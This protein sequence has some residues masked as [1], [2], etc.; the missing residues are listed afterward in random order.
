[1]ILH[2]GVVDLPYAHTPPPQGRRKKK[3]AA[4]TQT[5]GDVAEILEAEY[6]VMEHFWNLHS[7]DVIHDLEGS[8][9]GALHSVLM[10]SPVPPSAFASAESAIED[11]FKRFLSDKEMDALGFP[12]IPTQAA[13]RGVSKRHKRSRARRGPRPSFIDTGLYQASFK[14]WVEA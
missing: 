11:R 2:F 12:G 6:H 9:Q 14:A 13:L 5:T 4:G 10:G 3:A 1:M 7:A 8:L